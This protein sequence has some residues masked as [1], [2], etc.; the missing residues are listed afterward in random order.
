MFGLPTSSHTSFFQIDKV[1]LPPADCLT[2][3]KAQGL[4]SFAAAV[5]NAGLASAL[6]DPTSTLTIFAPKDSAFADVD[7][8]AFED[9]TITKILTYHVLPSVALAGDLEDDQTLTSL[10][11][12]T[13]EVTL[14]YLFFFFFQGAYLNKTS[15]IVETDIVCAGGVIHIIDEVLVPPG[16]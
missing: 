6:N 10:E 11:G 15:K 7:L 13:I 5:E 9:A 8:T 4:D 1:L 3:A 16:I 14:K 2:V 12:S